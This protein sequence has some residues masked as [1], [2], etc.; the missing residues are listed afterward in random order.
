M[1]I[2]DRSQQLHPVVSRMCAPLEMT[3]DARLAE[4]LGLDPSKFKKSMPVSEKLANVRSYRTLH[5]HRKPVY[6][7]PE[8][9]R[10]QCTTAHS[11]GV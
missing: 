8:Q 5:M 11:S 2:R 7:D 6:L 3:S 1:C 9:H 4:C 10:G